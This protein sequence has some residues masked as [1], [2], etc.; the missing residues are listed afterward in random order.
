MSRSTGIT[1]RTY[2]P[3]DEEGIVKVMRRCFSAFDQFQLDTKTWLDYSVDYGFKTDYS[4]VAEADGKI[5]G[6]VQ[7]I[8]RKLKLGRVYVKVGGIAN[9]STDPD[10]RGRGIATNLMRKALELCKKEGAPIS[11]LGTGYG[12]VAHRI[13]RRLG[14]ADTLFSRRFVGEREEAEETIK[15]LGKPKDIT[16]REF[17]DED[18]PHLERLYNKFSEE[19]SGVA[20]RDTEYWKNKIVGRKRYGFTWFFDES[21]VELL[22]AERSGRVVGYSYFAIGPLCK[23]TVIGKESGVLLEL[24][25]ESRKALSALLVESLK[26]MIDANVKTFDINLPPYEPYS[27]LLRKFNFFVERGI[28]MSNILDLKGLMN[29]YLPTFNYFLER[30]EEDFNIK[31]GLKS[32]YGDV[33]LKVH[34]NEV[35]VVNEEPDVVFNV[36]YHTFTRLVHFIE[37]VPRAF[38]EGNIDVIKV[39]ADR[40]VSEAL[41]CLSLLF[42]RMKFIIWHVDYW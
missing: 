29:E 40:S 5:V 9:V 22:V 42:P 39:K 15:A 35:K 13:Y 20:W 7:V 31:I 34:G 17:K 12:S 33:V 14:Y 1:Y 30:C 19:F 26:R 6:H 18:L 21:G 8:M 4:L 10:Y 27:S 23:R 36:N 38:L 41:R 16:V 28:Y 3:G 37:D 2:R 25:G 32:L 11:A 24:I